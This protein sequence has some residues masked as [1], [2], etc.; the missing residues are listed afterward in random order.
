MWY[1]NTASLQ[2][3]VVMLALVALVLASWRHQWAA[4]G[5]VVTKRTL[6]F[7]R[8]VVYVVLGLSEIASAVVPWTNVHIQTLTIAGLACVVANAAAVQGK[9]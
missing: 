5:L 6:G 1:A 7:V 3:V 4:R 9:I 8:A 2:V